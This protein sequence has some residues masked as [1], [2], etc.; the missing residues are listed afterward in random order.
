MNPISQSGTSDAPKRDLCLFILPVNLRTHT[1]F[2]Q[3]LQFMGLGPFGV[4]MDGTT[5][6]NTTCTESPSSRTCTYVTSSCDP[7]TSATPRATSSMSFSTTNKFFG[8]SE[9]Y[10]RF[11]ILRFLI[12]RFVLFNDIL[13]S[14]VSYHPPHHTFCH[15]KVTFCNVFSRQHT[16]LRF[17]PIYKT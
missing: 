16:N 6:R 8:G 12:L 10:W 1:E 17:R 15:K 7:R 5:F 9:I 13:Q 11:V 4:V 2:R 14:Y 3:P